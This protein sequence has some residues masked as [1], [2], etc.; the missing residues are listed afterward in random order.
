ML[1]IIYEIIAK[2]TF[3]QQML[4]IAIGKVAISM[5]CDI[6]YA[7]CITFYQCSHIPLTLNYPKKIKQNLKKTWSKEDESK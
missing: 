5:R 1:I 3:G 2:A 6:L 4:F 7:F